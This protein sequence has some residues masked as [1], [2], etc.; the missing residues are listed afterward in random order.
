MRERKSVLLIED[1]PDI[2]D[3]MFQALQFENYDVFTAEH[4]LEAL[5]KLRKIDAPGKLPGLILLDLMLPVMDGWQFLAECQATPQF[6]AIPIVIVS[7]SNREANG[8]TVVGYLRKP[9]DLED[10]FKFVKKYCEP[11]ATE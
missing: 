8:K 9:I 7:A 2:R 3:L 4:G 1:D 11:L 10:L 6:S 5:E